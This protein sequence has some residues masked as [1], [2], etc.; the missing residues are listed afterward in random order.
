MA[1]RKQF[2]VIGIAVAG[3]LVATIVFSRKPLERH[4]GIN[5]SIENN[6]STKS[7]RA[8]I[9]VGVSAVELEK[10]LLPENLR[11]R[12]EEI[13]KE[14][15][16]LRREEFLDAL[17]ASIPVEKTI[18]ALDVFIAK[19]GTPANHEL[20]MRLLHR[21][22]ESNS[23]DAADYANKKLSGKHRQDALKNVG[24]VWAGRDS[25]G[26]IAWARALPEEDRNL[27]FVGIAYSMVEAD[28][29]KALDLARD[30]PATESRDELVAHISLNWAAKNPTQAGEWAK[31]IP[32]AQLRERIVKGIAATWGETDPAAAANLALT[33]LQPGRNQDD[34]VVGIVQR[35]V[36]NKPLDAA[37]WVAKFPEGTSRNTAIEEVVKLWADK[38][39]E[40]AGSWINSLPAGT[41]RDR[42]VSAYV[43]KIVAE[44]PETAALWA[45]KIADEGQR[46][47]Y[48]ERIGQAWLTTDAAAARTWISKSGLPDTTKERL[49][50]TKAP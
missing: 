27:V 33:A 30:L 11:A 49:L 28:P 13:E 2:V 42:A 48:L 32:D 1:N 38:D 15:D 34:A 14:K 50:G 25:T 9:K 29:L 7:N 31:Q 43:G 6:A 10:L 36:Q 37:E 40:E 44:H 16:E 20:Q 26:A 46:Y 4:G 35:W 8:Q 45:G 22:A 18:Q 5:F 19:E 47:M 23:K 17:I 24:T 41:S 39:I 21:L 3:A 12:L